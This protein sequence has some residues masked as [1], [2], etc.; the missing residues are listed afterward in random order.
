MKYTKDDY[1][2]YFF[3]SR[4]DQWASCPEGYFLQGVYLASGTL[5]NNIEQ[6]LC[7]RPRNFQNV[8]M[9]CHIESV[10]A[11]LDKRGWSKC[12]GDL[13][14]VAG[15]YKAGCDNLYCIEMIKCC[16]MMPTGTHGGIRSTG[17]YLNVYQNLYF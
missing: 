6:A 10:R 4:N 14:F 16:K 11:S 13:Y 2:G 17:T 5:L 1:F 15:V 3:H 7:C 12:W 8:N 9:D